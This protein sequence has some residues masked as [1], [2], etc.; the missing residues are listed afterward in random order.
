MAELDIF[1]EG[2]EITTA[3]SWDNSTRGSEGQKQWHG[4]NDLNG[5]PVYFFVGKQFS[6][7]DSAIIK[8]MIDNSEDGDDTYAVVFDEYGNIFDATYES[9]TWTVSTNNV[10]RNPIGPVTSTNSLDALPSDKNSYI[11]TKNLYYMAQPENSGGLVNTTAL[12]SVYNYNYILLCSY[13]SKWI[14]HYENR[15]YYLLYNPIHRDNFYFW[16]LEKSTNAGESSTQLNEGSRLNRYAEAMINYGIEDADPE[17][18]YDKALFYADYSCNY[19]VY[20]W[21]DKNNN[22]NQKQ[23]IVADAVGF[24]YGNLVNYPDISNYLSSLETA[25]LTSAY[26]SCKFQFMFGAAFSVFSPTIAVI[27]KMYFA[28]TDSDVPVDTYDECLT[29]TTINICEISTQAAG[30]VSYEGSTLSCDSGSSAAVAPLPSYNYY[31][32]D[33]L[34]NTCEPVEAGTTQDSEYLQSYG[35]FYSMEP[36]CLSECKTE[37]FTCNDG[38]CQESD[39]G[40]YSSYGD[41]AD[42]CGNMLVDKFTCNTELG[43][44]Q[45]DENSDL[46]FSECSADCQIDFSGDDGGAPSSPPSSPPSSAD[47]ASGLGT[48]AIVGISVGSLVFLIIMII[49]I[50]QLIKKKNN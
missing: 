45:Q 50:L 20:N 49:V 35:S 34:N 29:P 21:S 24:E 31:C 11:T 22:S 43:Y 13:K 4:I 19:F 33:R 23:C 38:V 10:F 36:N 48:G 16:L 9:N 47:T 30:N 28:N 26:C 5:A 18:D 41:C 12:H 25:Q 37:N 15:I 46:S 6:E 44:C 27:K 42:N 32:T 3:S 14:L 40:E 7:A 2:L 39:T 8:N 1:G 17:T